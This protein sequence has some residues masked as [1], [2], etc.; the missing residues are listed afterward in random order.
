VNGNTMTGSAPTAG[1]A[2]V[3]RYSSNTGSS[4][5]YASTTSINDLVNGTQTVSNQL[6]LTVTAG[7]ASVVATGGTP[8]SN[9]LGDIERVVPRHELELLDPRRRQGERP[10]LRTRLRRS[11]GL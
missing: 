1:S 11:G 7:S 10:L 3:F 5:T 6:T 8:A 4:I 9:T 2:A